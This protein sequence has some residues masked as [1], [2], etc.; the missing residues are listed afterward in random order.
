MFMNEEKINLSFPHALS[1]NPKFGSP[2]KIF[3]DDRNGKL[4]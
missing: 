2:I 4:I 3:G 1:G